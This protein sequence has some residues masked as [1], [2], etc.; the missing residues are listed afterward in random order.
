M[1]YTHYWKT[2][3][4][5]DR[6]AFKIFSKDAAEVVKRERGILA[7]WD[8]DQGSKPEVTTKL[9][10]LNGIGPFACE[11]FRLGIESRAFDFCKTR[12]APYDRVVTA[13]LCL[14]GVH[15]GDRID[16]SSDG[17]PSDWAEGLALALEVNEDATIPKGVTRYE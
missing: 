2:S 14:A 9:V 5:L 13:L 7:D 4:D 3:K 12:R 17:D 8:G 11:T 10:S 15:F 6:L 16:I 1:G